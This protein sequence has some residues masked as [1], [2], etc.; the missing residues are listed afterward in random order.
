M[1]IAINSEKL[2]TLVD[3][4]AEVEQVATGFTFT[5]DPSG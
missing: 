4:N 3:Q 1:A 5:E 2:R